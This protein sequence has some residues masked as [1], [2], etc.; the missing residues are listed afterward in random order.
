MQKFKYFHIG[1]IIGTNFN[2]SYLRVTKT[3]ESL[4]WKVL[5]NWSQ[6]FEFSFYYFCIFQ[7]SDHFCRVYSNVN[8]VSS[9]L[10]H[11]FDFLNT[12]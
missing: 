9:F 1:L 7:A 10:A 11:R 12:L 2:Y 6:P 3:E 4:N 5:Q 8:L